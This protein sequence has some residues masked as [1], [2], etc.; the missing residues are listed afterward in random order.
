MPEL[1]GA[2]AAETAAVAM[3][4]KAETAKVIFIGATNEVFWVSK[5]ASVCCVSGWVLVQG[6]VKVKNKRGETVDSFYML[7][8]KTSLLGI[9]NDDEC[10]SA[11]RWIAPQP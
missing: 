7:P 1:A 3:A 9:L 10:Q 2:G 11:L 5:W 8:I 4:T 6:E